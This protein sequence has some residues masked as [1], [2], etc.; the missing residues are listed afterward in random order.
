MNSLLVV[1]L[2]SCCAAFSSYCIKKNGEHFPNA[3]GYLLV[4]YLVGFL[5]SFL[6]STE[7][8]RLWWNPTVLVIG[9]VTGLFHVLLMQTISRAITRGPSGLTFAFLNSG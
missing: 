3:Q 5:L 4:H 2:A 9:A 6:A 7:I 8:F 1:L